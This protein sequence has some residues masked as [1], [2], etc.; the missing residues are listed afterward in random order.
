MSLEDDLGDWRRSHYSS[1]LQGMDGREVTL[2]GYV[3]SIRDHGNIL[4]VMLADKDG[5]VQL[6]FKR[7]EGSEPSAE[8]GAGSSSPSPSHLFSRARMLREHSSIAVKGI[9]RSMKNAPR[10]VEVIPKEMRI[11]SLASSAPPFSVYSRSLPLDPRLDIRAVD[12]RRHYL[13]AVFRV[14]HNLLKA[15]RAYLDER[16]FLEVSTPKMIST[17]SEGGAALFPIFYFDREAFLA[18][19]PQLYKEQLTLAFEKVYEIAPIFRAEPSRTNRHL[20]EAISVDVEQAFVDYEDVM[21]TLEGMI[22]HVIGYVKERC[23]EEFS[24]LGVDPAIPELPLPRYRYSQLIDM[25]KG[26]GLR[27]EWGDDF[28]TEHLKALGSALKGYYFIVDWPASMRP[29]YTKVKDGEGRDALS[30][31]FDLMYGDLEVSSGSTRINR[32][33]ELMARLKRQGLK[34]ESF[35]YHLTVFDYGMPPHA[36]FGLGL[37]R[38]LMTITGVE[39]IRDATF[40]PRDIDRLV[41]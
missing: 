29:F 19:S 40:Y 18:Q 4:F 22:A 20:A 11:L 35:A 21:R 12:L 25:L 6:V 34:P 28:G 3:S 32:K 10:G 9:A 30:E 1:E 15:I 33:D 27:I 13:R 38:F 7:S 26:E 5:E 2:M 24:M 8:P 16:G 39:N 36:G 17:A 31:S 23:R 41:P 14:R 37:E